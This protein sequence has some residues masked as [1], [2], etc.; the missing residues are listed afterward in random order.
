MSTDV[1]KEFLVSL[2]FKI[3]DAS[4]KKFEGGVRRATA[5]VLTLGK[6]SVASA[7]A[8]GAAVEQVSREYE[9]LYYM[10][11][12]TQSTVSN[13]KTFEYSMR[14]IGLSG[15]TSQAQI[16]G[17]TTALRLN[18]GAGGLLGALGVGG[19]QDPKNQIFELTKSLKER[20]GEGGYFVAARFAQQF[21]LEEKA[22]RGMWQ[23]LDRLKLA[24]EDYRR[25]LNE[26]GVDTKN[27]AERS[28]EFQNILRG[29]EASIGLVADQTTQRWLPAATEIVTWLDRQGQWVVALGKKSEG[30]SSSILTVVTAL[31]AL[32]VAASIL[33]RWLG[34]GLAAGALTGVS[35]AIGVGALAYSLYPQ[36]A[37]NAADSP[38][39]TN[40][41]P[42]THAELM[43]EVNRRAGLPSAPPG[44]RP[45]PL[46]EA[47]PA[48]RGALGEE[49]ITVSTRGGRRVTV[50]R[51][52]APSILGFLNDLEAGGAPLRSIGGY[53]PR[54]IAGTN[55]WSEHAHG[56]AVDIDQ[57]GRNVVSMEFARWARENPDV[58]REALR[59][60]NVKSGGDFSSPD[61]GHFEWNKSPLAPGGAQGTNVTINQNTRIDVHGAGDA[62]AAGDAVLNGQTRVNADIVRNTKGAVQ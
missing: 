22:F 25:R 20:F 7:A 19:S 8:V 13:L 52:A 47:T 2:G 44:A 31:G 21:G 27:L 46:G 57:S 3:D 45:D 58:L 36:E 62:R 34:G 18:P 35:N 60:N 53:N 32:K 54:A 29:V 56:G 10:S 26:S 23:N 1:I 5:D 41:R 37:G 9:S 38:G 4:W 28:T 14:Q 48:G 24:D 51:E 59:R 43:A 50:S 12:R 16:E 61:F 33:P 17:F 11:Q 6:A 49:L 30:L 42:A 39:P 40:Q 15:E 55:K